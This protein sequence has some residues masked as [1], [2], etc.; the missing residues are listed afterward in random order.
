MAEQ[1]DFFFGNGT[2]VNAAT[3]VS[4]LSLIVAASYTPTGG[5]VSLNVAFDVDTYWGNASTVTNSDGALVPAN[6]PVVD[7]GTG[8]TG[9]VVPINKMFVYRTG[10][11]NASAVIYARFTP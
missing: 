6:T 11:G 9:N 7:S 8:L 5:C 10:G 3:A 1:K 2:V 4:V